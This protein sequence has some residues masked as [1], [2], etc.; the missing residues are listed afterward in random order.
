MPLDR[1]FGVAVAVLSVLHSGGRPARSVWHLPRCPSAFLLFRQ[2]LQIP[3]AV[4]C[5][6]TF[7][8]CRQRWQILSPFASVHV[9][10]ARLFFPTTFGV[11]FSIL[12]AWN[13][14]DALL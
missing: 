1:A 7:L 10:A 13:F 5:S 6:I 3:F 12:V 4:P 9:H 2:L 11:F 8:W 14:P